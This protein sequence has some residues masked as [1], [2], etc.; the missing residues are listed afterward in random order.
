MT[1]SKTYDL[2]TEVRA[3]SPEI[4]VRWL[5]ESGAGARIEAVKAEIA[6]RS[7]AVAAQAAHAQRDAAEYTRTNARWTCGAAMAAA[8]S[9][10]FSFVSLA[11]QIWDHH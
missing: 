10:L 11:W 8:I 7:I 1:G 4:L 5:A 9:A 3:A 2:T 6:L